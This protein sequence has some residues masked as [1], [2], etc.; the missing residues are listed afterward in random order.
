MPFINKKTVEAQIVRLDF[1]DTRATKQ[2]RNVGDIAGVGGDWRCAAPNQV[3]SPS[4]PMKISATG[5]DGLS[6]R[7]MANGMVCLLI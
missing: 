4:S 1:Q 6:K 5:A 3:F 7:F 2:A